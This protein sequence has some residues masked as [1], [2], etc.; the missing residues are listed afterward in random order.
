LLLKYNIA[1]DNYLLSVIEEESV[2]VVVLTC[3]AEICGHAGLA[4][5]LGVF[6]AVVEGKSSAAKHV[7]MYKCGWLAE[8]ALKQCLHSH[9]VTCAVEDMDGHVE[10]LAPE[11]LL[12][13]GLGKV[14]SNHGEHCAVE[15]L[16]NSVEF[17]HM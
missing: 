1:C 13:T 15:L 9:G 10:G 11:L 8:P 4:A 2:S 17:R 6:V 3:W 7:Y 14:G 12:D 16:S 5:Q